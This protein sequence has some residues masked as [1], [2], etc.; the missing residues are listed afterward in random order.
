MFPTMCGRLFFLCFEQAVKIPQPN[1]NFFFTIKKGKREV[2]LF[3]NRVT[4]HKKTSCD[5]GKIKKRKKN[6]HQSKTIERTI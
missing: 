5:K 6:R 4:D 2:A 1:K 3:S